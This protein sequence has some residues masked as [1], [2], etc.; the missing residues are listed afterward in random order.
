MGIGICLGYRRQFTQMRLIQR[1]V[2]QTEDAA[3]LCHF[4]ILGS[5]RA[6]L[7]ID[8]RFGG[9]IYVISF[10]GGA[11]NINGRRC[12]IVS[13]IAS[14][15]FRAGT[16]RRVTACRVNVC[17]VNDDRALRLERLCHRRCADCCER[18]VTMTQSLRNR[19]RW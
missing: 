13:E 4:Q 17:L 5:I 2:K 14:V 19:C 6:Y 16:D 7:C 3:I 12:L 1:T 11:G 15:P 8:F 18:N 10:D 9:N